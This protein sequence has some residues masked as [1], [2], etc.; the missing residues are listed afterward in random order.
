MAIIRKNPY[1][2]LLVAVTIFHNFGSGREKMSFRLADLSST[3]TRNAQ[4]VVNRNYE[5]ERFESKSARVVP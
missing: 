5:D 2:T 1:N 3:F 4:K